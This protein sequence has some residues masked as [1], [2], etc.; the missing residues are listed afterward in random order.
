[1]VPDDLTV[2][3]QREAMAATTRSASATTSPTDRPSTWATTSTYRD[4]GS[5]GIDVGSETSETSATSASRT[6]RPSGAAISRFS[7]TDRSCADRGHPGDDHLEHLLLLEQAAHLDAGH[8]GGG[9]AT[10]LARRQAVPLGHA[11]V[12]LDLELGLLR[13][14][15]DGRAVDSVQLA[16]RSPH[17]G[18]LVDE[19]LGLLA[20]DAGH[21]LLGVRGSD[22]PSTQRSSPYVSTSAAMPG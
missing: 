14:L 13:D 7:T 2:V 16:Q 8:Q 6:V 19:H 1:M 18:R 20:V 22:A 17:L 12:H 11:Q 5:C 15:T 9:G 4:T 10:D 21:D 3:L